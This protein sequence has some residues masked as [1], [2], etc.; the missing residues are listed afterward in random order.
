MR[1]EAEGQRVRDGELDH[2]LPRRLVAA[3]HVARRLQR[4]RAGRAAWPSSDLA[5]GGEPRRIGRAVDQ[6]DAR[7]GLERLDAARERGLRDMPRW[8][9]REKLR[10]SARLTKSSSHLVSTAREFILRIL[11]VPP[12]LLKAHIWRSGRVAAS[13]AACVRARRWDPAPSPGSRA[14][15][16]RWTAGCAMTSTV[17]SCAAASSSA[18]MA[19]SFAESS[20]DVASSKIRMGGF[21][22]SVRAM[23]TR[24]CRRESL[25]PRSPTM[26]W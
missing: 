15:R 22:N 5:G 4:C 3:Q 25:R 26:V 13:S 10:V 9:E 24:C 23:A 8:A 14:R 12:V 17:L 19:R 1:E 7:P 6:I 20:A 2:V 11:S 16:P 18:W 21:F